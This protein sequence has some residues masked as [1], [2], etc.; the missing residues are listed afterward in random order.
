MV[1]TELY[2]L[3][4]RHLYTLTT[5]LILSCVSFDNKINLNKLGNDRAV[6]PAIRM[7]FECDPNAIQ[8]RFKRNSPAIPIN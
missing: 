1:D 8:M 4:L 3:F 5:R 7:R 2:K 6:T